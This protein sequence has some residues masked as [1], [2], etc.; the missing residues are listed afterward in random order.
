MTDRQQQLLEF[1]RER[2]MGS[3]AYSLNKQQS[4]FLIDAHDALIKAETDKENNVIQPT[5][6]LQATGAPSNLSVPNR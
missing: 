4:Q 1:A 5:P 2:I 3:F 6:I